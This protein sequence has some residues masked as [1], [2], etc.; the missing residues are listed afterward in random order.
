MSVLYFLLLVGVL[1]S[2]HELGHFVAAKL[3][4]V[5][6]VR[7]SLG[8]G[9]AIAKITGRET[10]YQIGI[11]PLGGYVKLYGEDPSEPISDAEK[12]RSFSE[13]PLWRRLV[14]VFA[15][16]AANLLCPLVIYFFFFLGHTELPAAVIGDIFPG[17]PAAEA[18]LAP[19]DRVESIDGK[20]IRYWEELERVVNDHIGKSLRFKVK[21]GAREFDTYVVPRRATMRER[22]GLH[23]DQGMIGVSQ[24][25]FRPQIGVLDSSSA[26]A[27]AGLQTGDLV[28]SV[29]GEPTTSYGELEAALARYP[30]HA[31]IA[32][33]RPHR[34]GL[35]FAEAKTFEP[36]TADLHPDY[37]IQ[38]DG[39][40]I[41]STGIVS[42]E[43]FIAEVEPDSPA[44]RAGLMPGDVIT[45]LDGKP[46][47]HWLSFDQALQA[48]PQR[49]FTISW[50]RPIAA[51]G[52]EQHEA[53]I[54]QEKRRARDEYGHDYTRLVFGAKNDFRPGR[55]EMLPIDGRLI[56]AAEHAGSRTGVTIR[57]MVRGFS[58]IIRGQVPRDTVGGPIMMYRI[59]SVSGSKG[60]DYFVLMIALISVN[61]GLINLLPIPILD[62]GHLVVFAVEAVRRRRLSPRVREAVVLAGLAVIVSLTVLA[63]RNDIV[64]YVLR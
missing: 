48:D 58:S 17:G 52:A 46:V 1:V 51:G 35:G 36:A 33:V 64:R 61:L 31:R 6:V 19:G 54:T 26:A 18:G 38:P 9:P 40:T 53:Q 34:T 4:D 30:K 32:Y 49:A 10:E 37:A 43:F 57:E 47:T 11:V 7:F 23:S 28:I 60:W 22:N 12:H 45:A 15:G 56:Y 16:P 59:A 50:Q 63:L 39:H 5:K 55:G 27:R 13:K 41:R 44:E 24:G 8:F 62:G 14:V 29:E 42:A 25:P 2:I 21:R 3:L 20:P